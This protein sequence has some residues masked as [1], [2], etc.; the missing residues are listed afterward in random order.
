MICEN[1][2][3]Y[4]GKDLNIIIPCIGGPCDKQKYLTDR[5]RLLK[6]KCLRIGDQVRMMGKSKPFKIKNHIPSYEEMCDKITIDYYIYRVAVFH[7]TKDEYYLYL[8]S[9]DW[10]DKDAVKYQFRK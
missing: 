6:Y 5:E 4:V 8:V 3:E 9:E 7:F 1:D 10:S 2:V